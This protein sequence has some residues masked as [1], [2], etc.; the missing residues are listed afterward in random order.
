MEIDGIIESTQLVA[1]ENKEAFKELLKDFPSNME[2]WFYQETQKDDILQGDI[3]SN[4]PLI[5]FN[6]YR[7]EFNQIKNSIDI[8]KSKVMILS[9]SC[10]IDQNKDN[11]V[12]VAPLTSTSSL[13]EYKSNKSWQSSVMKNQ[14][15]NLLFIP[16]SPYKTIEDSVVYLYQSISIP[17][18]FISMDGV[19]KIGSL[20]LYGKIFFQVKFSWHF[21]RPANG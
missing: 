8:L 9:H 15:T 3:Y 18:D 2:K 20:S 12:T 21:F 17:K 16:S 4:V 6:N 14:I 19:R 5:F 10:D 13:F 11:F 1:K 7:I